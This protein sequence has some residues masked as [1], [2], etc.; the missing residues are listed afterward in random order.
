MDKNLDRKIIGR[1]Q[2]LHVDRLQIEILLPRELLRFVTTIFLNLLW[3]EHIFAPTLFIS[4]PN[5]DL[6]V[7]KHFTT[8]LRIKVL[9]YDMLG[10][11]RLPSTS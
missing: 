8:Y 1:M 3:R 4:L 2:N 10:S 7:S 9:T 6:S 5:Y 11:T